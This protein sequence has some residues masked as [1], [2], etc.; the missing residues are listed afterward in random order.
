MVL[1][2]III[3][4]AQISYFM[5]THILK[6]IKMNT[7]GFNQVKAAI[8]SFAKENQDFKYEYEFA[9]SVSELARNAIRTNDLDILRLLLRH[10][11]LAKIIEQD[12]EKL[13]KYI[14]SNIMRYKNVPEKVEMIESIRPFIINLQ[15]TKHNKHTDYAW[16]FIDFLSTDHTAVSV[17]IFKSLPHIDVTVMIYTICANYKP[18]T[19]PFV[20]EIVNLIMVNYVKIYNEL[21]TETANCQ[22]KSIM[23]SVFCSGSKEIFDTVNAYIPLFD[24]FHATE[25]YQRD[26]V[27]TVAGSKNTQFKMDILDE[28][29]SVHDYLTTNEQ[30]LHFL[31]ATDQ[32]DLSLKLI[33]NIMESIDRDKLSIHLWIALMSGECTAQVVEI[34]KILIPFI[35]PLQHSN[36]FSRDIATGLYYLFVNQATDH[37]AEVITILLPFITTSRLK[38]YIDDG[39]GIPIRSFFYQRHTPSWLAALR[40]LKP[41]LTPEFLASN[42]Y[43]TALRLFTRTFTES[44]VAAIELIGTSPEILFHYSAS[45]M[46]AI[47]YDKYNVRNEHWLKMF[48]KYLDSIGPETARFHK[49]SLRNMLSTD[50]CKPTEFTAI[51]ERMLNEK[52]G[53]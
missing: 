14:I 21:D 25:S 1:N 7:Y 22:M 9:S 6:I 3:L 29:N 4:W 13:R 45:K 48:S 34:T 46:A 12:E 18:S 38:T 8:I 10:F 50:E 17:D 28:L 43:C 37:T 20:V 52:L 49:H 44:T 33:R 19:T 40:A 26:I 15:K 5:K 39:D 27:T 2:Y 31:F 47:V 36:S 53:M 23:E 11:S 24:V 35:E 32:N 41:I 16:C 51:A 42:Q 30:A